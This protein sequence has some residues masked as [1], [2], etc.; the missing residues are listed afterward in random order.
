MFT[1]AKKAAKFWGPEGAVKLVFE[2]DPRP[3]GAI[4]DTGQNGL[5]PSERN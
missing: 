3:G 2:L 5:T 1:D 4:T